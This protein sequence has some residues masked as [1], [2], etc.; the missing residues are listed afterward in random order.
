GES[1][2]FHGCAPPPVSGRESNLGRAKPPPCG[3][4]LFL[5]ASEVCCPAGGTGRSKHPTFPCAS[6][7]PSPCNSAARPPELRG[8]GGG[9]PPMRCKSWWLKGAATTLVF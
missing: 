4:F 8:R 1:R 2:M 3:G 6:P 9:G 5:I 7:W